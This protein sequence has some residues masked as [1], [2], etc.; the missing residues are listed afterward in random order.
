MKRPNKFNLARENW[1]NAL[2]DSVLLLT[3]F[4]SALFS[5]AVLANAV[6]PQRN[7]ALV[8]V[9]M[10]PG[11]FDDPWGGTAQMLRWRQRQ[12]IKIAKQNDLPVLIFEYD[13]PG[14]GEVENT[15]TFDE[16]KE[17]LAGLSVKVVRK[18]TANGFDAIEGRK[19]EAFLRLRGITALVCTGVR[20]DLCLR[21]TIEGA[22]EKNFEVY[23]ASELTGD[24]Y[25]D[26][27]YPY[28]FSK[29]WNFTLNQLS[30]GT[31]HVLPL[32]KVEFLLNSKPQDFESC[33]Q[34]L[35]LLSEAFKVKLRAAE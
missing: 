15:R 2:R 25:F 14:Y 5:F 23:T 17:A 12:L 33:R 9:D 31:L 29:E 28:I 6:Y 7:I 13:H 30:P 20:A 8:I 1:R 18:K 21:A 22:I 16:I 19:A 10:Q 26:S 3:I 4:C 27:E 35:N 24:F 11:V 34:K 32:T